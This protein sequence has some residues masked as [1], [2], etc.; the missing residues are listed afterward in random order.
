MIQEDNFEYL[1][2]ECLKFNKKGKVYQKYYLDV[3]CE[4]MVDFENKK[5]IFPVEIVGR[6]RNDGF[7]KPENFVVFECVDRLLTKG[8]RPEHIELEKHGI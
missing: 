3:N 1:V 2:K 4:M 6:E 5:L 8:Y 7:D